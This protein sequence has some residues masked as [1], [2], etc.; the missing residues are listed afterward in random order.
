M[1]WTIDAALQYAGGQ[2]AD[3]RDS[4]GIPADWLCWL[5]GDPGDGKRKIHMQVQ[6]SSIGVTESAARNIVLEMLSGLNAK[7]EG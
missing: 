6:F 3:Y 5:V 7:A 2:D 1:A 4:W